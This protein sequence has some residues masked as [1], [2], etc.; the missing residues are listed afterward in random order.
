MN[1]VYKNKMATYNQPVLRNGT[2]NTTFNASDFE[3]VSSSSLLT[4]QIGDERYMKLTGVTFSG[5]VSFP[6]GLSVP[7]ITFSSNTNTQSSTQLGYTPSSSN[8]VTNPTSST[9]YGSTASLS[10][11]GGIWIVEINHSILTSS[12][13]AITGIQYGLGINSTTSITQYYGNT[14]YIS[15]TI[16]SGN[17]KNITASYVLPLSSTSTIYPLFNITYSTGGFTN[18]FTI[19]ATR[20][21]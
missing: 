9:M 1:I 8:S 6:T 21:A 2:L 12:S 11:P 14:S 7:T 20:V 3:S 4:L 13:T 17:Y 16:A 10:L 19:Q 5:T 18:T 15:E